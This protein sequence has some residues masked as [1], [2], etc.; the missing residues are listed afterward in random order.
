MQS[1]IDGKSDIDGNGERSCRRNH[2]VFTRGDMPHA[3]REHC[4]HPIRKEKA[5]D[6]QCEQCSSVCA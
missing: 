1:D 4:D 5:K 6:A 3:K 2:L